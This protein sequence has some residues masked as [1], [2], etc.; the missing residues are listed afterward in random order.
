[1]EVNSVTGVCYTVLTLSQFQILHSTLH[2]VTEVNPSCLFQEPNLH[3]QVG[4]KVLIEDVLLY[5][6][7]CT[8]AAVMVV[9]QQLLCVFDPHA[10]M[11]ATHAAVGGSGRRALVRRPGGGTVAGFRFSAGGGVSQ[12]RR[13]RRTWSRREAANG[14]AVL[15]SPPRLHRAVIGLMS[16]VEQREDAQLL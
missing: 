14:T 13:S 1:M 3:L 2:D 15:T 16:Q 5:S 8:V 4:F 12:C 10:V 11:T 7:E 9:R 6:G